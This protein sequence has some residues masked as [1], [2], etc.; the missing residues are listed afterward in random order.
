MSDTQ[1]RKNAKMKRFVDDFFQ[2]ILC[3]I[4]ESI[5]SVK[6]DQFELNALLNMIIM[7]ISASSSSS[8]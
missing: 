7:T 3:S 8:S 4:N 1:T 5:V 6:R 2:I